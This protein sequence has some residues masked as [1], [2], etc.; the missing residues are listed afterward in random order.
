MMDS[1]GVAMDLQPTMVNIVRI[2]DSITITALTYNIAERARSIPERSHS[3]GRVLLFVYV[4]V[5]SP[6][7]NAY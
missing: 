4:S 6:R 2:R 3:G 5:Q 1:D 7:L